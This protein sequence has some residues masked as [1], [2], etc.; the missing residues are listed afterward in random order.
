[1]FH[2][3]L[4]DPDMFNYF[5]AINIDKKEAQ[6][7]FKL[8][9]I[10]DSGSIDYLDF[11]DGCLRLKGPAKAVDV[12]TMLQEARR[13]DLRFH[14]FMFH[15]QEELRRARQEREALSASITESL[16]KRQESAERLEKAHQ[17]AEG[18]A[19]ITES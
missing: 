2:A 18:H 17:R 19:R 1:M 11:L 5:N 6:N 4:Q 13:R 9:D 14:E 15:V 8:L 7:L 3:A 10:S 12:I 16:G